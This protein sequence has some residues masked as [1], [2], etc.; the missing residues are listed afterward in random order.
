MKKWVHKIGV[1]LKIG[2]VI[3]LADDP[4]DQGSGP[5]GV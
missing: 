5:P 3:L 4:A 1:V 2:V